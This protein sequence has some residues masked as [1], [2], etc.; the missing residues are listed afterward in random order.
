MEEWKLAHRANRPAVLG[1]LA[2]TTALSSLALAG[3]TA[4]AQADEALA[5]LVEQVAPS[6]VTVL[7]RQETAS[8]V[9]GMDLEKRF[10]IPEG[11]PFEHFFKNFGPG[12]GFPEQFGNDQPREGLGSGFILD[13]E[14]WLVT[15]NHV[16]DGADSV[17]VRLSDGRT[18]DA[19]IA[20]VDDKTD[21]ALLR[22]QADEALPYVEL[23]DS[24]E[25]RVGEDV[26]AVGNPFGLG[27]TVTSG[28]VSAKGRNISDGPYAEFL[29]TDAAINKGNSG[30]PLF[31]MEGEVVGVN[32]AI[33]SPTGGSVGVGFAVTSN[34]VHLIVEDL[35]ED[36]KIDRG[37]LGVSIQDVS[38]DL[39]EALGLDEPTGALVAS[40][41][42]DSPA[43]REILAGDVI[44]EFGG[45]KVLHSSALPKL[46]AATKDGTETEIVVYRSG[47][48]KVVT[49]EIDALNA[50]QG[51]KPADAEEGRAAVLKSFGA[52]VAELDES[53]RE[54]AGLGDTATGVV[55]TSLD[56][57]GPAARAGVRVGDVILRI[58]DRE[59][60]DTEALKAALAGDSAKPFLLLVNRVGR[61]IFL[62]VEV[63]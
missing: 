41:V 23:G 49:V 48:K 25:I 52:T 6:V 34:I 42:P 36:G 40:V 54:K 14:G 22:I 46:V 1:K 10:G 26:M 18:F 43:D 3:T 8:E 9:S 5:D 11:S 61:Q 44:L 45:K 60:R 56:T 4:L 27:G 47:D 50:A 7:A 17:T 28:I 16:V 35:K 20:G 30:G 2:A 63:A 51:S 21:L 15:N 31:N 55:V 39:A 53:S 62:A 32:S 37:W 33:Y 12:N 38:P 24:D 19:E 59:V 29:Q 13:P 58:G 57:D